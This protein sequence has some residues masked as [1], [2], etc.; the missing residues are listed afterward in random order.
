MSLGASCP[1]CAQPVERR[2]RSWRCPDHG[3]IAPL[4]RPAAAGYDAFAEHVRRCVGMP[5]L[6]PWPVPPGWALTDFGCVV[7]DSGAASASFV[8]CA[9]L[10]DPDGVVE[11]TVIS[12]EPGVGLGSRCAGVV[13][14]DPGS[15]IGAGPAHARVR[16]GSH[17]VPLWSVLTSEADTDFDRSVF[18]GEA[19]G[20]WLWLVLRPASAALLLKDEWLLHD[21]A[22]LGPGLMELPFVGGAPPAW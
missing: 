7:G 19:M 17:P 6:T 3:E 10:N 1:R 13:R 9:G 21:V 15:E 5:T 16:I 8:T 22:A 18:A 11:L 20:R 2:D 14:T 12:E 4:W